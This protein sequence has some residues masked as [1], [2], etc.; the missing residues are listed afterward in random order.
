MP[1]IP[2]CLRSGVRVGVTHPV[3][4]GVTHL[5]GAT[6]SVASMG[7]LAA[8]HSVKAERDCRVGMMVACASV[9]AGDEEGV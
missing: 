2:Q 1:D 5:G 9:F 6:H 3:R 8:C 7:L 4:V